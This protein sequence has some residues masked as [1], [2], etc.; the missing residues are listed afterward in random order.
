MLTQLARVMGVSRLGVVDASDMALRGTMLRALLQ[1]LCHATREWSS[2]GDCH[3]ILEG[4]PFMLYV[5][6]GLK[7]GETRSFHKE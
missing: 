3:N 2:S 4:P 7:D 5:S 6:V 1:Y